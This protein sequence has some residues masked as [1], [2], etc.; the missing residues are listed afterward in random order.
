MEIKRFGFCRIK[1]PLFSHRWQDLVQI[2]GSFRSMVYASPAT[3]SSTL[4]SSISRAKERAFLSFI[5]SSTSR[6]YI[7]LCCALGAKWNYTISR[8]AV[9]ARPPSMTDLRSIIYSSHSPVHPVEEF[10]STSC[11]QT[12]ALNI[13]TH[14]LTFLSMLV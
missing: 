14:L 5:P 11:Y 12:P 9:S 10:T 1:A 7:S 4:Q 13:P 8:Y 2:W 3:S 6:L